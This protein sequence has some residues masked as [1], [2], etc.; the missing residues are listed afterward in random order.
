MPT[1]W[2]G[3]LVTSHSSCPRRSKP[4]CCTACWGLATGIVRGIA[5]GRPLCCTPHARSKRRHT[6]PPTLLPQGLRDRPDAVHSRPA[7][8]L[9]RSY[10]AAWRH[11]WR[12]QEPGRLAGAQ[13]SSGHL[14]GWRRHSAGTHLT[15]AAAAPSALAYL[16]G[17]T[18]S[19]TQ[20]VT[21]GAG[22][23]RERGAG[24]APAA[25]PAGCGQGGSAASG[26]HQVQ[27][28]HVQGG[29]GSVRVGSEAGGSQGRESALREGGSVNGG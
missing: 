11:A 26:G 22:N 25:A 13:A 27:G 1:R 19:Q 4:L 24:C 9:L 18:P 2:G 21:E 20:L 5:G 14:S 15:A 6:F 3:P 16:L 23:Q 12:C 8:P 28:R 7:G 29:K 17:N 10:T